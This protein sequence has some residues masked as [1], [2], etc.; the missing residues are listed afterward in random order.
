MTPAVAKNAPMSPRKIGLIAKMIR[1][2]PVDKAL[3]IL[4]NLDLKG[5]RILYK[6]LYS[7]VCNAKQMGEN[8]EDLMVGSVLVGP[9]QKYK[10]YMPRARGR[11]GQILKRLTNIK[12]VLQ[13]REITNG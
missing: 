2:L 10:R 13:K 6:L 8:E 7:S 11:A 1:K 3:T 12:I 5:A 4:S 9:G